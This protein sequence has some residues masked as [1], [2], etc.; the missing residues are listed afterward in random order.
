MSD[1]IY[2]KWLAEYESAH[3]TLLELEDILDSILE[4]ISD[5]EDPELRRIF[6]YLWECPYTMGV[7]LNRMHQILNNLSPGESI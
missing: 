5:F 7:D 1:Y 2:T 4:T 3:K 6:E